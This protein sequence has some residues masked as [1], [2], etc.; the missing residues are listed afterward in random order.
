VAVRSRPA[1][2][3]LLSTTGKVLKGEVF[4]F[5]QIEECRRSIVFRRRLIGS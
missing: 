3:P 4:L 2:F 5:D 1:S